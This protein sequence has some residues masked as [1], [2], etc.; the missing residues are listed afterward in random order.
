MITYEP[1]YWG[2]RCIF[3]MQGSVFP[4]AMV[5]ATPCATAAFILHRV[6][7]DDS[8]MKELIGIGDVAATVFG[9]FNFILG[10][11]VVFRSQQ[12]YARWWEGGT[13][14]QQLRG[15]WFNSFS[16]LIAFCNSAPE[17]KQEVL[18]FQL[19]MVRLF[20]L[21][22][23]CA[24]RQVSHMSSNVFELINLEGFDEES[25]AF[26]ETCPDK[27]EVTL[28]WIQ[29]LIV[30]SEHSGVLKIAPPILSRVYNELGN[31]IVNLNNA[32]KIKDFLIPF[33]L[34]QMIMVMLA[35]HACITPLV[36]AAT[37]K[38]TLWAS[39][40][41]FIVVFS[42]WSVLYIAL[43]L[44]MP[45]GDDPN[46]LPL[47]EMAQDLNLSLVKMMEPLASK[48][49][50]FT[51]DGEGTDK[52]YQVA[53]APHQELHCMFVD[54]DK[55]L[56]EACKQDKSDN[57]GTPKGYE[58][59][60]SFC[61]DKM[62]AMHKSTTLS[63]HQKPAPE[64]SPSNA[65][66]S[67][68]LVVS[69]P[70]PTTAPAPAIV[71]PPAETVPGSI[72][73]PSVDEPMMPSHRILERIPQHMKDTNDKPGRPPDISAGGPR[74]QAD[75]SGVSKSH[76]GTEKEIETLESIT[77]PAD[78]TPGSLD[79][80]ATTVTAVGRGTEPLLTH[81]APGTGP[82]KAFGLQEEIRPNVPNIP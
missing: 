11:L 30:E 1:G 53:Q 43:E 40:L 64:S 5:W 78:T 56:T 19:Q 27:C 63:S 34:A 15:E 58:H 48:V 49:P 32:R 21:T 45:F 79:A 51:Y 38:T 29:R 16:C 52:W 12:A 62:S 71:P 6:L 46:D 3:Q 54:L 57:N 28:Q 66:K 41:T 44:E 73:R 61:K 7:H 80:T 81:A 18:K 35:F 82:V 42:Y 2:L 39:L 74:L 24:L 20:S 36:C 13:L 14:L 22:Y 17:K 77:L 55:E 37:V 33:P 4:K 23:G 72:R 59:L 26:L 65:S 31:G 68:D 75:P 47:R 69:V 70:A 10:F 60:S 25:L 8:E 50:N 9:G 76:H 67:R